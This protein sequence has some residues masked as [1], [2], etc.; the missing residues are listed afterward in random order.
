MQSLKAKILQLE[1]HVLTVRILDSDVTCLAGQDIRINGLKA[2]GV[3]PIPSSESDAG[4]TEFANALVY[5]LAERDNTSSLAVGSD[6][7]ITWD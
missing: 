7:E 4:K 5:R 6:C 1:D 3:K 2:S